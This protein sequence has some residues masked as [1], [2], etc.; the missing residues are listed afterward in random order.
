MI[1]LLKEKLTSCVNNDDILW[2]SNNIELYNKYSQNISPSKKQDIQFEKEVFQIKKQD[3]QFEKKDIQFEKEVFQIKKQDIQIEKQDIQIEKEVFQIEKQVIQME[4]K[5]IKN[6]ITSKVLENKK[7]IFK[8]IDIILSES[9]T[10]DNCTSTVKETLIDFISKK[11]FSTVFGMKKSAE[12]MSG[13]V[14]NRW[15]VST[16]LF[17]SFL[18]NK[19][20][21][22]NNSNIIYNKENIKGTINTSG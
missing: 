9:G 13:I 12:I 5:V 16:A 11:E 15:N 10:F 3:I 7:I 21:N 2:K 14:N 1:K 18:F 17:I 6:K 20:V 4:K 8:P 19:Q 22:Y